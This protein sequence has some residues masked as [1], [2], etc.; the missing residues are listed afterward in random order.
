MSDL[1]FAIGPPWDLNNHVQNGLLLIGIERDI[2]E[3]RHGVSIL[4]N[5]DTVLKRIGWSNL[6]YGIGTGGL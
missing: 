3:W 1:K 4:F 2:M 6:P 5:V